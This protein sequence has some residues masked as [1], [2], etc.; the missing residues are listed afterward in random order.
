[1]G[2]VL[3]VYKV[4]ADPEVL[5]KVSEALKSITEGEFKDMRREPIGFGIEIIRVG[6]VVPDKVDGAMDA[7]EAAIKKIP[8]VNQAE[9]EALT[10]IDKMI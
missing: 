3:V 7:L 9:V 10:L 6:Y 8:G 2:K 5:E 4:F 1:M